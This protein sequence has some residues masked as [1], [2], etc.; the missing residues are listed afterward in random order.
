MCSSDLTEI[1]EIIHI[2]RGYDDV[3]EKF[4]GLGAD[5]RKER[6]ETT[7]QVVTA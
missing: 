3:V 4:R 6:T 2:E 5:M 7:T 1:D